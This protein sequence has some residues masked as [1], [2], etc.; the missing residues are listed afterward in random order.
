MDGFIDPTPSR[1]VD[2]VRFLSV[3]DL[4][5]VSAIL[6]QFYCEPWRSRHPP[7]AMLRLLALY[8]L[9][10]YRFLTELWRQLSRRTVKRLGFKRRPSYQAVW[11]WLNRRLGP[12][13]LEA[14]HLALIEAIT[15]ALATR[16]IHLGETVVGDATPIPAKRRDDDAAY[17]GY[18][19]RRCYL[20]HHLAC[21]ATGV[22]LAW[23]VTPGDVDEAPF[24][25]PLLARA[26]VHG[27]RPRAA[28]FDNGYASH[29][30]YEI[31]SL[32]GV[33]P[34][35]GFRRNAKPGWRG[36]PETLR[37][38]YRKRVKA[39]KLAPERRQTLGM[40]PDPET[41]SLDAVLCALAVAGQHAY[42]GAYYRNQSL[43]AFQAD[44]RGWLGRYVP[45]RCVVEGGHGHQKDWLG[46]GDLR[47]TGLRRAMLHVALCMLS[48]AAVACTRVQRGA[49]KSL[50]SQA[51]IR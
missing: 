21:S 34:R 27:V 46:L 2:A 13:G 19:Q 47:G 31:P 11:H 10:R 35:I 45:P 6:E 3:L 50:T 37:R 15:Q 28:V 26:L 14:I 23:I 4:S 22:T 24:A 48:E 30:N 9:R 51:Y 36:K 29:W 5:P 49:V 7:E 38:R 16:G 33:E 8:K 25:V 44:R 41:N 12:D 18:Y 1:P 32:L 42:V 20:L 40:R 43:A 17:N 39:G